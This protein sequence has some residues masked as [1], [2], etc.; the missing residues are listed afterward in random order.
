M[1]VSL[2]GACASAAG[3]GDET[4]N[5]GRGNASDTSGSGTT[6]QSIRFTEDAILFVPGEPRDITVEVSPPGEYTVRFTLLGD[7]RDAFFAQSEVSTD[8]NG[9]A[10]TSLTAPSEPSTFTVRASV[11]GSIS[12]EVPASAAD[13]IGT[14]RVTPNYAGTREVTTWVASV[15]TGHHCSE[16]NGIPPPDGS[17]AAEA[18]VGE[19][20]EVHYVPIGTPI[21]VTV[22]AGHFAGGCADT[23]ALVPVPLVNDLRV[24]VV[25]RPLQLDQ[26]D[27]P[28]T[29]TAD[30]TTDWRSALDGVA[31]EISA[32]FIGDSLTD[33]HALLDAMQTETPTLTS[34]SDFGV[35]R[36]TD[37]WDITLKEAL[38][39]TQAVE[40]LRS[41]IRT[42][43]SDGLDGLAAQSLLD[44][45][46][47]ADAETNQV[48]FALAAVA[49]ASPTE[50]G[51]A[52]SAAA[53]WTSDHDDTV[54]M[55]TTLFWTPSL[56]LAGLAYEPA[57]TAVSGA[58][59]VPAALADAYSCTDVATA[60]TTNKDFAFG[61]CDASCMTTLCESALRT[62]WLRA[63]RASSEIAN[64]EIAVA[65]PANPIDDE[66]RPLGFAGSWVGTTLLPSGTEVRFEGSANGGVAAFD[67]PK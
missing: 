30:G 36:S 31:S 27:M 14:I 3:K 16:L 51:F 25:D 44:G 57:V 2:L 62:M 48:T 49:G 46:I 33:S 65:G 35:A 28:L 63:A 29:L 21:A 53:T 64:M 60:L 32:A 45:Q 17:L 4:A 39:Y 50:M 22:R 42:W 55:G 11:A 18:P 34:A 41:L 9:V 26:T 67:I 59:D 52:Q 40:G 24:D 43:I 6:A 7:P 37:G 19:L 5:A 56:L 66:A 10:K 15:T 47:K 12:A 1:F 20:P 13:V 58:T 54:H 8:A 38:G 61:T 23:I